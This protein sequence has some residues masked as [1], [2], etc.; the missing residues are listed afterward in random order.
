MFT[1]HILV[2]GPW[3]KWLLCW[4][5]GAYS[6]NDK[7]SK[8]WHLLVDRAGGQ[9]AVVQALEQVLK[10]V[11]NNPESLLV[12]LAKYFGI[13]DDPNMFMALTVAYFNVSGGHTVEI[14]TWIET[15]TFGPSEGCH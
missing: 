2:L 1:P 8:H 6:G 15:D 7:E 4:A 3:V 13:L 5:A 10:Q 12:W 11:V 14:K 9:H